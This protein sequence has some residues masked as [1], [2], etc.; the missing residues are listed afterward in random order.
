[1]T[2]EVGSGAALT[3][4]CWNCGRDERDPPRN[5]YAPWRIEK[6]HLHAGSGSMTRRDDRRLI[7]LLCSRCHLCHTHR[8]GEPLTINGERWPRITD[9][10][11]LWLKSLRD[12]EFYD[13][14]WLVTLWPKCPEPEP[15]H[16]VW[17]FE[18]ADRRIPTWKVR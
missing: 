7:C 15:T 2:I 10:N 16:Y 11:M 3:A 6:A 18:Y 1:M 8:D 12:P 14:A 13:R 4:R 9:A 5:W 17:Q